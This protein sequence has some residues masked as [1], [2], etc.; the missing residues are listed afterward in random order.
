LTDPVNN[1][2][3]VLKLT[4]LYAGQLDLV[5]AEPATACPSG[6]DS[7]HEISPAFFAEMRVKVYEK[8][9]CFHGR[10]TLALSGTQHAPRSGILMLLVRD[11]QRVKFHSS[12]H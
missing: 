3:Y 10:L 11:E 4:A 9:R 7:E 8:G 2:T 1:E 6:S 5:R 12:N